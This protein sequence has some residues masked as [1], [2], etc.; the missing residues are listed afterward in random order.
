M[1]TRAVIPAVSCKSARRCVAPLRPRPSRI[2]VNRWWPRRPFAVG[3]RGGRVLAGGLG[4]RRCQ[5]GDTRRRF[6]PSTRPSADSNLSVLE[7]AV[8]GSSARRELPPHLLSGSRY[9]ASAAHR[10]VLFPMNSAL[11]HPSRGC[12]V[13]TILPAW[14][15][16]SC[17]RIEHLGVAE[18][19]RAPGERKARASVLV[20]AEEGRSGHVDDERTAG[21][22]ACET[23][24]ELA[25]DNHGPAG[26]SSAPPYPRPVPGA[27]GTST[28]P[29][30]RSEVSAGSATVPAGRRARP[31]RPP[32]R[33][34]TDAALRDGIGS[35]FR[36]SRSSLSLSAAD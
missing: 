23:D 4:R 2:R 8:G 15:V 22:P 11:T 13:N 27:P 28:P 19:Q 7:S 16:R 18:E 25:C 10:S 9:V 26:S 35:P 24:D 32:L 3:V 29:R 12:N 17:Q 20:Q 33:A 21:R 5:R 31:E 1:R 30:T 6:Q 14:S 34:T 36:C